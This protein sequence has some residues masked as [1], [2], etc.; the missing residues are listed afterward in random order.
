MSDCA[1]V[2]GI[3][4]YPGLRDLEGP[5]HDA[6]RFRDWLVSPQGGGLDPDNVRMVLTDDFPRAQTATEAHPVAAEL[7]NVFRDWVRRAARREHVDGRLFLF[8]AGHGFADP[9]DMDSAALFAADAEIDFPTHLAVAHYADFFRR[10][11][12]FRE[13]ILL[14]DAC[15][16]TNPLH[17]ISPPPLP[18]VQSHPNASRVKYFC[19]YAAAYNQVARERPFDNE[20]VHGIFTKAVLEA[21]ETAPANRAGRVNGTAIKRH[22]HQRI[23]HLAGDQTIAPPEIFADEARDVLFAE[24]ANPGVAVTVRVAAEHVGRDLIVYSGDLTELERIPIDAPELQIPLS[25]GLV[26]LRVA[27]TPSECVLEVP[28]DEPVRL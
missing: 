22:V 10:T 20:P 28:T 12:A 16:T 5:C 25:P 27:G 11:Y 18:H 3:S 21:L 8:V 9:D 26:K 24:R 4:S 6:R 14:M 7:D 17:E 13:I 19:G 23:H 1:V 15:R 2:I